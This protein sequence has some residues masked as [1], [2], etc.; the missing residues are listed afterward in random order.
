MGVQ[1]GSQDATFRFSFDEIKEK[2]KGRE[3]SPGLVFENF[4]WRIDK[5]IALV[6][7]YI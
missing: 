5:A 7:I 3:L 6:Q 1:N 2:A 4:E